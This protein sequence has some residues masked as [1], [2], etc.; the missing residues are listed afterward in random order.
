MGFEKKRTHMKT[1]FSV[2]IK[3]DFYYKILKFVKNERKI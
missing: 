3:G 1:M 2:I